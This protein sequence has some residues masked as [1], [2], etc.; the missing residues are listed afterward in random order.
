MS[1]PAFG[2]LVG[3]VLQPFGDFAVTATG[4]V[5]AR[6][7]D[8][9]LV[10]NIT[11]VKLGVMLLA[12]GA[13]YGATAA[14]AGRLSWRRLLGGTAAILFV[15]VLRLCVEIALYCDHSR[16]LLSAAPSRLEQ[17]SDPLRQLP[18][19]LGLAAL[20]SRL[21]WNPGSRIVA[22]G[23][24]AVGRWICCCL[25]LFLGTVAV[26]AAGNLRMPSRSFSGA[27]VIDDRHSEY[28]ASAGRRMSTEWYGDFSTYNLA[29][30][31]EYLGH[32]YPVRV[33]RTGRYTP[34][35]LD[36]VGVLVLKTPT[37][38]FDEQE[39]ATIL[40][41]VEAGGGLVLLGDH[42][43]L[44]GTSSRLNR[45]AVPAGIA[46]V[47]DAVSQSRG[48]GFSL[49]PAP[50]L[51]HPVRGPNPQSEEFMTGC[52]L[53]L[54][55]GVDALLVAP[56]E[57][58][59]RGDYS[60]GSFFGSLHNDPRS[61]VGPVAHAA[62]SSHGRG[63]VIAYSDSTCMSSFGAFAYG[64]ADFLLRAVDFAGRGGMGDAGLRWWMLALGLL[65]GGG[66]LVLLGREASP[67]WQLTG[68]VAVFAGALAGQ[69][70]VTSLHERV[71]PEVRPA[72]QPAKLQYVTRNTFGLLP[73][74]LGRANPDWLPRAYDTLYAAIPRTGRF[75]ELIG[76]LDSWSGEAPVMFLEPAAPVSTGQQQ[77]FL[78]RLRAGGTALL[79]VS[80]Q[81][82]G[83]E[84]MRSLLAGTSLGIEYH[85]AETR[86]VRFFKGPDDRF[87]QLAAGRVQLF[88]TK[89]GDGRLLLV[90]GVEHWARER[91]GHAFA[92]PEPEKRELYEALYAVL[93]RLGP[94]T[95]DRRKYA[96]Q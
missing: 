52:S 39:V 71:W 78:S 82:L 55:P 96:L 49:S 54:A 95:G 67:G 32:F 81:N 33:N 38:D 74:V 7:R 72:V 12:F 87:E 40:D 23:A 9:R 50:E 57:T 18:W 46:F 73:P 22:G 91:L 88:E 41:F 85:D 94:E 36:D 15:V 1:L 83:F 66:G 92:I 30:V 21:G 5:G 62:A 60:A 84:T 42:T 29:A 35:S 44:M 48:G 79:G 93:R 19:L 14:A 63:T 69:Q 65:A 47:F 89:V 17:F 53:R 37:V 68:L 64:R 59:V 70:V 77:Q 16:V 11:T 80:S 86:T 45:F 34:G 25:A 3:T 2:W 26:F 90:V 75:P 13:A 27:V 24:P 76:S 31:T 8:G 10:F 20:L 61:D 51:P 28:W 43:N 4:E 6:A 56:A 58:R